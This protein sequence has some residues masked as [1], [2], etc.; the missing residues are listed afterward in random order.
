MVMAVLCKALSSRK[1][2]LRI[3]SGSDHIMKLTVLV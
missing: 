1:F 3:V 2:V